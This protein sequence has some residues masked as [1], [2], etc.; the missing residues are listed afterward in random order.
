[1]TAGSVDDQVAALLDALRREGHIDEQFDQLLALQD[2]SDPDFV[3]TLMQIFFQV[4]VVLATPTS[5]AQDVKTPLAPV[6]ATSRR[7][8]SLTIDLL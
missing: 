3:Q 8:M 5:T 4:P 6:S 2:D 1:M 7:A